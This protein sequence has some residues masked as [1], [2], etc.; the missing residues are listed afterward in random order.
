MKQ[1]TRIVLWLYF[2][3]TL[4]IAVV[5]AAGIVWFGRGR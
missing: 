5:I 3:A 4:V 1:S 2:G